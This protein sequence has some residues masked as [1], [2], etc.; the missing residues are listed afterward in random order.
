MRADPPTWKLGPTPKL[1]ANDGAGQRSEQ[2]GRVV[3]KG[4]QRGLGSPTTCLTPLIY[5]IYSGTWGR[6]YLF[7]LQAEQY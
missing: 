2:G 1:G 5:S 6:Q 7:L 3:F 4:M